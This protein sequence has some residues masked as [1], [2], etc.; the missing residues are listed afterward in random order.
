MEKL[1]FWAVWQKTCEEDTLVE[2]FTTKKAAQECRKH[3]QA[4]YSVYFNE[5][6]FY[7]SPFTVFPDFDQGE[8][9]PVPEKVRFQWEYHTYGR[10][11]TPD[12]RVNGGQVST[13]RDF[14][15]GTETDKIFV[16][17]TFYSDNCFIN[18]WGLILYLNYI[19]SFYERDYINKGRK[20]VKRFLNRMKSTNLLKRLVNADP[21]TLINA[22]FKP[23]KDSEKWEAVRK[24]LSGNH[25]EDIYDAVKDMEAIM[26]DKIVGYTFCKEI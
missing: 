25:Y 26:G 7:V 17:V 20:L 5:K 13:Y 23:N 8:Y 24:K 6:M 3:L 4:V 22:G 18:N 14:L 12:N 19:P 2:V 10:I 9:D 16:E 15:T 21:I 1:N 11:L